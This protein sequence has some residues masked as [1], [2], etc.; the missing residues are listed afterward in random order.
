[1]INAEVVKILQDIAD[2]LEL[3]GENQFKKGLP[4]GCPFHRAFS[5]VCGA[6]G[7]GRKAE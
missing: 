5:P 7:K 1:M 6:T 3:K 4:A 2:L